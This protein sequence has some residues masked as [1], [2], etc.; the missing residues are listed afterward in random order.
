MSNFIFL[1]TLVV[2]FPKRPAFLLVLSVCDLGS[3]LIL[4]SYS[5]L[6]DNLSDQTYFLLVCYH[7]LTLLLFFAFLTRSFHVQYFFC[8]LYQLYR[9]CMR[10][11]VRDYSMQNLRTYHSPM[12]I[13]IVD[14]DYF[15]SIISRFITILASD[16]SWT[17]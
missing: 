13:E 10:S 17:K 3:P 7:H 6:G 11:V 1:V 15:F 8:A 2:W 5:L 9:Y 16:F 14:T 12:L 4:T